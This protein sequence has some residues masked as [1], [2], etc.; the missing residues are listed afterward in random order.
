M[1]ESERER[2]ICASA[3]KVGENRKTLAAAADWSLARQR[4]VKHNI[5]H[6][7]QQ[8]R[9]KKRRERERIAQVGE[10]FNLCLQLAAVTDQTHG[11]FIY[12]A[13]Q[14]SLYLSL[15]AR[16]AVLVLWRKLSR[17]FSR[18]LGARDHLLELRGRTSACNE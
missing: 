1:N 17:I 18:E 12:P 13:A 3:R 5:M 14:F 11:W 15:R 8:Y 9:L 2:E 10:K 7:Q 6:L 4:A 16:T